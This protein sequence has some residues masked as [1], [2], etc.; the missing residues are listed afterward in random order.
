[1][2]ELKCML[3]R[4]NATVIVPIR[5]P[6]HA[7]NKTGKNIQMTKDFNKFQNR[8]IIYDLDYVR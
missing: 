6:I 2:E 7:I 1:M 5:F 8:L 3:L 4:C